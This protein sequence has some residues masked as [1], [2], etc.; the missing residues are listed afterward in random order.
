[1]SAWLNEA[2]LDRVEGEDL[3]V[4]LADLF[5]ETGG[6][7]ERR[8]VGP[9]TAAAGARRTALSLV[10]DAGALIAVEQ[11]DRETATIIEAARREQR[12]VTVPASVVG[13]VWRG[14]VRQARLAR[15]SWPGAPT[16]SPAVIVPR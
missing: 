13:Q 7:A 12:A 2:G 8:R 16:W 6:P 9:G 4:V 10:L 15:R 14:S 1:M 11:G 3:A 5:N